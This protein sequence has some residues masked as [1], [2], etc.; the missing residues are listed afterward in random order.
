[1]S[2][3]S[4]KSKVLAVERLMKTLNTISDTGKSMT[5]EQI[6]T[7]FT[8]DCHMTFNG[9]AMCEG[10][11]GLLAHSLDIE[12]KLK[13]VHFNLPFLKTV[14]EGENVLTYYT[15]DTVGHDDTKGTVWDMCIYSV[16][17][18]KISA[19]CEVVHFAGQ[20]VELE[21]YT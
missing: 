21:R 20:Q 2:E 17:E 8:S 7:L 11:D 10:Y 3:V 13:T 15:C 19:V 4:R 1:M 9:E 6:K 12:K 18:G 5:M 14:V 16:R